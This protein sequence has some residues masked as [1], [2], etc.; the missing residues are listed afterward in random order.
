MEKPVENVDNSSY[1]NIFRFYFAKLC[2]QATQKND[3]SPR[4]S[5][6]TNGHLITLFQPLFQRRR[7]QRRQ[8]NP[9]KP[10]FRSQNEGLWQ[11]ITGDDLPLLFRPA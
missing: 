6:G 11:I 5:Q 1:V 8:V 3:R 9:G 2:K 4:C 7:T 10:V